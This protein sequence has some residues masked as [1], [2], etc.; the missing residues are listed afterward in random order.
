MKETTQVTAC[1]VDNGLGIPL[2]QRL[3]PHFKRFLYFSEWER[4]FPVLNERIMGDGFDAIQRVDD[5]WALKRETDL[6]IFPDIYR[7][8]L[9][10]ELSRQGYPVWGSR[11]ADQLE[12]YRNHFLDTLAEVGLQVPKFEWIRGLTALR[13]HLANREN[14]FVKVSKFRG[15]ME[16]F[17]WRDWR[18]DEGWLDCMAVKL[19][20]AQD[21][22]PFLVFDAIETDLEL[23]GDT[24]CIDGKFPKVMVN[25]LECKDKGYLGAVTPVSEMPDAIKA[26]LSAFGIILGQYEMRNFWSMEARVKGE[27]AFFI[28]PT[29]RLPCPAGGAHLELIGNLPE[30]IWAGANGELVEPDM[31]ANFAAECVLTAKSDKQAWT[32][33]DFPAELRPQVKCGFSCEIDGRTCFPPLPALPGENPG[34]E[35]GFLV[36]T[37][38]TIPETIS[39]MKRLV[40]LLPDGICAAT[41]SLFDLLKEAHSAEDEGIEFSAQSV[42]EPEIAMKND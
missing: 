16:T 33:V 37:G 18:H 23:G 5:I 31:T 14:V 26:I 19:G 30:V 28:D 41:D 7:S 1:M 34:D 24:Y 13:N 4:A 22:F 36:S 25:G 10:L 39:E 35:I 15:T 20:P 6:Y 12:I 21:H 11:E 17:H 40:D 27:N 42:P 3:A 9:Q 29:P 8:G 38:D 32:V 2:A